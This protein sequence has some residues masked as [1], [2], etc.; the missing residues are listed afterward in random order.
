MFELNFFYLIVTLPIIALG[1]L[2]I[3]HFF[4][5]QQNK[6]KGDS[7]SVKEP[8]NI[9]YCNG[10]P[11]IGNICPCKLI[12]VRYQ[13]HDERLRLAPSSTI[14]SY[15]SSFNCAINNYNNFIELP[16]TEKTNPVLELSNGWIVTKTGVNQHGLDIYKIL[17]PKQKNL[18]PILHDGGNFFETKSIVYPIATQLIPN[19]KIVP[20]IK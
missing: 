2:I 4:N 8:Q 12:C 6:Q 16:K 19:L 18:F 5:K 14:F 3:M 11:T 1:E 17:A 20:K 15:V 10:E 9:K 7:L 13:L